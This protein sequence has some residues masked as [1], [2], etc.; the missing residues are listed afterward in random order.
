MSVAIAIL[1]KGKDA[2]LRRRH[3]WVFSGA[4]RRWEGQPEDGDVVE[5]RST[6]GEYLGTG[7]YQDASIKVRIFSFVPTDAGTDFWEAKLR[8]ALQLR[9]ALGLIKPGYNNCYRLAHGEGDGLP[10]LIIDVYNRTAVLQCHSIGMHRQRMQLADALKR[11]LGSDLEAVYDKSTDALP[12]AYGAGVV[13]EYLYGSGA[14]GV[15]LENGLSFWV[16]W[17][18]G[19]KTGFFLDQRD[20][21]DMLRRYAPGKTVL[22]AFSYTGGFSVYALVAGAAHVDSVDISAK[23]LE[24]ADRNVALNCPQPGRHRSTAS[25]VLKFLQNAEPNQYDLMVVDPPAFAKSADKRHNAV[26]AYKR[27]NALAMRKISRGGILFTFSC[28]QVVNRELFYHTIVAA[29]LEAGR[30]A[31]VLHH[32]GQPPDHPVNLFHPEGAYLKGLVLELG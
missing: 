11:V 14:P 21:R 32:L 15:A 27:L 23:A 29:A 18:S 8:N 13:Q 17:E 31:R 22:N 5:V 12:S 25:D 1:Q 16:D 10:G 20:N 24:V 28:S 19:Q 7:H 26:Q 4:I 2:P 6:E 3:P 9:Q 30:P